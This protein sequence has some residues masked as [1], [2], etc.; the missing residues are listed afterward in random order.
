MAARQMSTRDLQEYMKEKYSFTV[1]LRRDV[2]HISL[3]KE[4]KA[5][6]NVC[7]HYMM[8]G[9]ITNILFF[10]KTGKTESISVVLDVVISRELQN[11]HTFTSI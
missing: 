1:K 9:D 10:T 8:S 11:A 2:G 7:H 3:G 5:W 4:N 6:I